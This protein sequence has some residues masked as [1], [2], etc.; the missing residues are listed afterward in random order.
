MVEKAR[1]RGVYDR[2]AVSEAVAALRQEMD[3]WDLIVAADV[4]VYLGDLGPVFTAAAAALRPGGLFAATAERFDGDG[5]VLGP[6]R[7]YAHAERYIRDQAAAADLS[8]A[9]MEPRSP[10]REKGQPVPGLLFILSKA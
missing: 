5:F 1:T 7:R 6:A 10:R 4:L 2:L 3:A 9:V 8:V